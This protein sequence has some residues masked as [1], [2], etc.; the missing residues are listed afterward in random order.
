MRQETAEM[1]V[2]TR[3]DNGEFASADDLGRRVPLLNRKE[4]VALAS[5][6]AL[7]WVG[8]TGH[9]RDAL[10]QIERV[11]RRPGPLLQSVEE[12]EDES[13]LA[14]M[15][16][17]ERIAA[18]FRGTGMTVG[19]HPMTYYRQQL[20]KMRVLSADQLR[21][22]E[23]GKYVR[24]AGCI[25]ARQRPGT[26]KGFVF[27]SIEDETGISNVIISPQLYERDRVI[28]STARFVLI[29]GKLQNQDSVIHVRA[30]QVKSLNLNRVAVPSHDFH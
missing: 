3:K 12:K 25:I 27:L 19:P 16:W 18:D 4:M 1:L 9:R 8:E 29:E 28:V 26:A 20:A 2:R 17:E 30:Q 15:S 21:A 23:D 7:N 10:W 22:E 11:S 5:I 13:P 6:G 14:R 24:I